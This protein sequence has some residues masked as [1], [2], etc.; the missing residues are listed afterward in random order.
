MK[1]IFKLPFAEDF[2][3]V[4]HHNSGKN[5]VEFS[6]FTGDKKLE[7]KSHSIEYCNE[8]DLEKKKS[9]LK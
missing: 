2:L 1:F 8:E 7:I 3:S 9:E 5:W 4:S 6:S